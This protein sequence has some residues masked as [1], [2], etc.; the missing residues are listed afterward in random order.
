MIEIKNLSKSYGDK[1]VYE[2]FNL[3]IE[4]NEIL[5]VLGESGSGKTTLLNC[6]AKLIGYGGDITGETHP[7][8]YVFREDRL[9]PNLTVE[10]NLKLFCPDIDVKK[11]LEKVGLLGEEN[12]YPKSLS[13]G[14]S[15][16]VSLVRAFSYP[17]KVLLMDEP[18]ANLDIAL[19]FS[20]IEQVKQMQSERP[21]TIV[22]VTH[23]IKE[24]VTLA[25]RIVA[26]AHGKIIYDNKIITADTE[27]ELFEL[28]LSIG[29][30]N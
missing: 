5:V 12:A 10:K 2:N 18:F 4:T 15:K 6:I 3:D 13:A 25:D 9:I 17:S 28:M 20:L 14:M 26:I 27:K 1:K 11:E 29:E 30:K 22:M 19:K 16:R 21:R 24:A 7:V 23:D 8:S